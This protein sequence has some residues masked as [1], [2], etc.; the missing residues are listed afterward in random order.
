[1]S[2]AEGAESDQGNR[3]AGGEGIHDGVQDA[4]DDAG[5]SFLAEV[6]LS[7]DFFDEFGFVHGSFSFVNWHSMLPVRGL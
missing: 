5:G 3:L 6:I 2:A 7:G 1:M 4:V